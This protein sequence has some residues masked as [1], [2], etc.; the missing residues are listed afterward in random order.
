MVA[1]RRFHRTFSQGHERVLRDTRGCA[2]GIFDPLRASCGSEFLLRKASPRVSVVDISAVGCR[3]EALD[4]DPDE[5]VMSR[6]P[7][8][9]IDP[10]AGRGSAARALVSCVS[11][12]AVPMAPGRPSAM[13]RRPSQSAAG[14]PPRHEHRLYDQRS[15]S[16]RPPDCQSSPYVFYLQR[17][18]IEH[19][20]NGDDRY[21]D[22]YSDM[23]LRRVWGGCASIL[24]AHQTLACLSR[25][26]RI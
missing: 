5:P 6:A 21:L 20:R 17:A 8:V 18:L 2:R 10:Q 12:S 1:L 11:I 19:F 7:C 16:R 24:V 15:A 22:S 3:T 23:A 14:R 9:I 26:R 13:S 25:R 4:H